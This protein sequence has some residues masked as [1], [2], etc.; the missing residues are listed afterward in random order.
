MPVVWQQG[1]KSGGSGGAMSASRGIRVA[2]DG[3]WNACARRS[4]CG[5]WISA[6]PRREI[7]TSLLA[8]PQHLPR[9]PGGRCRED[10]WIIPRR[11]RPGP[12]RRGPVS[13]D[14]PG[15]FRTRLR[16]CAV[17]GYGGLSAG[18]VAGSGAWTR[19]TRVMAPGGQMLAMFHPAP[20]VSA[21][22][23]QGRLQPLSPDRYEFSR[24]AARGGLPAAAQ[25][26]QSAGGEAV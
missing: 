20:G 16:H 13:G 15:F 9:K 6:R 17:L 18:R 23:Y 19:S 2:G 11:R 26:H 24:C 1:E 4:R 7:S 21:L 22:R 25:L 3:Y 10:G 8:R 12:I 14:P 5:S